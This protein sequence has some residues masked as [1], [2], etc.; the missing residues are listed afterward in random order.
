[1]N[2]STTQ[3]LKLAV[4]GLTL[5]LLALALLTW[6]PFQASASPDAAAVYKAKCVACH[7]PDGKGETPA[8]KA[9]KLRDLGSAEVQGQSDDALNEIIAKGKGKMPAYEKTLGADSCKQLVGE[10]RKF[11]R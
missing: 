1:M 7:G 2:H 3:T 4:L 10:I 8:G 6:S 5:P 9:M 11:R